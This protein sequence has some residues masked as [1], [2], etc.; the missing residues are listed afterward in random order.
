MRRTFELLE[1]CCMN[2]STS[3]GGQATCFAVTG[4]FA[5]LMTHLAEFGNCLKVHCVRSSN[6]SP[7][8]G[9]TI[10]PAASA[11]DGTAPIHPGTYLV[12]DSENRF[13]RCRKTREIPSAFPPPT[14]RDGDER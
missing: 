3:S 12:I 4:L 8:S 1:T 13:I 2:G 14:G 9:T 7:P 5:R 11:G 10:I 6:K